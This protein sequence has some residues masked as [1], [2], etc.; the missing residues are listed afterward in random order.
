LN[1]WFEASPDPV[2]WVVPSA[3]VN[4]TVPPTVAAPMFAA[5]YRTMPPPAMSTTDATRRVRHERRNCR[6]DMVRDLPF[7][8]RR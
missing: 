2:I 5:W 4:V 3:S 6:K 1:G 7:V 8:A